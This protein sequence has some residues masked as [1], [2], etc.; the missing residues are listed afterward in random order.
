MLTPHFTA[1]RLK[2]LAPALAAIVTQTVTD[3]ERRIAEE[4]RADLVEHFALPV[5]SLTICELLGVPYAERDQFQRLS[6]ARF[7]VWAA[8]RR[9]SRSSGSRS[10]TS[11]TSSPVGGGSR[12]PACSAGWSPTMATTSLTASSP[13]SPT[14][15]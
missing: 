3:L 7:D 12:D 13:G 10:P 11:R 4:G 2:A 8:G 5:P 15:C 6:K 14:D 1:H 9:R